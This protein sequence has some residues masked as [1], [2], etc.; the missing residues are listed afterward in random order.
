MLMNKRLYVVTVVRADS[1][2]EKFLREADDLRS[3]CDE[4]PGIRIKSV[5][6][7]PIDTYPRQYPWLN[8]SKADEFRASEDEGSEFIFSRH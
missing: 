1:T 3:L 2:T 7:I 8:L 6:Q 4:M 5:S